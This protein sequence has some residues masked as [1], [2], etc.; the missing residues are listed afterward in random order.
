MPRKELRQSQ[1]RYIASN[2]NL[3]DAFLPEA[4]I[5]DLRYSGPARFSAGFGFT[6]LSLTPS[7]SDLLSG[8]G[9]GT[10]SFRFGRIADLERGFLTGCSAGVSGSAGL[11]ASIL[12][13]AGGWV[14]S[15]LE[16]DDDEDEEEVLDR[17]LLLAPKREKSTFATCGTG[18]RPDF[19]RDLSQFRS[20]NHSETRFRGYFARSSTLKGSFVKISPTKTRSD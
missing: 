16:E 3:S 11:I 14:L 9:S 7:S 17:L 1:A 19:E 12:G 15:S 20:R 10:R 6:G 13:S 4:S 5:T 18:P 2:I 8:F